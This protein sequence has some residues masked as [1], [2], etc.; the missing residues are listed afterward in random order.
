MNRE[1]LSSPTPSMPMSSSSSSRCATPTEI[2]EQQLNHSLP[3]SP[4][5]TGEHLSSQRMNREKL[6]SPRPSMPMSSSSYSMSASPTVIGELPS[7]PTLSGEQLSSPRQSREQLSSPRPNMQIPSSSSS[8]LSS[9]DR[10]QTVV[11]GEFS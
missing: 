10:T 6:S 2:G 5:L 3:S 9:L 4:T 7:S 11:S 8:R 1:Q